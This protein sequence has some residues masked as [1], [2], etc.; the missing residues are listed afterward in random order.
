MQETD[1]SH[2]QPKNG[3]A[4][5]VASNDSAENRWKNRRVEIAVSGL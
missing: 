5:P 3:E 4:N 2:P 1:R